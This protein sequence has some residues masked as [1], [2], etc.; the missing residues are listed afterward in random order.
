MTIE[1]IGYGFG[2]KRAWPN[3]VKAMR[4]TRI[5]THRFRRDKDTQRPPTHSHS[6]S[7]RHA[8]VWRVLYG[9]G[10]GTGIL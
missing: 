1:Q 10:L 3:C 9:E 8:H 5:W 6:H 7:D 4:W 2:Q